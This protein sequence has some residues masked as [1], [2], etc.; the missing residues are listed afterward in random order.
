MWRLSTGYMA[1]VIETLNFKFYVIFSN[2]N[3]HSHM[4]TVAIF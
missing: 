2:S 1:S 3:L 4:W